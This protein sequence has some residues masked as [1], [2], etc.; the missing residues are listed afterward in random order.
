MTSVIQEPRKIYKKIPGPRGL[1]LLGVAPE[2]RK[3]SLGLS[4]K[5]IND[6]GPLVN[7]P[8][9]GMQATLTADPDL[10]RIALLET[11]RSFSK[12]PINDRLVAVIGNGLP[13]SSG[14]FWKQQRRL[15]NPAFT[16][17]NINGFSDVLTHE[18]ETMLRDWE[19]R[20][21]NNYLR[22]D[23]VT[24]MTGLTL[25]LILNFLFSVGIGDKAHRIAE[26]FHVL[27]VYGMKRFWSPLPLPISWPTPAN[28]QY[29]KAR[30][31]LD[32]I[33][34][35]IINERRS[36]DSTPKHDLLSLLLNSIDKD[37]GKGMSDEQL[38]DELM[39]LFFAGHDTTAHA[40]SFTFHLLGKNPDKL[41]KTRE[42]L[43]SVLG[44]RNPTPEDLPRLTYLRQ[45]F[46]E[47]LRVYPP[48]WMINRCPLE[49]F[50]YRDHLIPANSVI[51]LS[52][53]ALHRNPRLWERPDEFEPE[54]FSPER[55]LNRHKYAFIPFGAGSR[56]C[57]GQTL[58]ITESLTVLAITLQRFD[59]KAPEDFQLELMPLVT[60]NTRSGIPLDVSPL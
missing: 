60:L 40:L 46:D 11:E 50:E 52:I 35:D 58:A 31:E 44:G 38:R 45:V 37:T 2:F 42:E 30:A 29:R 54:R 57:I 20:L 47:A 4:M 23:I 32:S 39:S 48:A 12:A 6:Y 9:P 7:I 26:C 22:L 51:F 17:A 43:Q 28:L 34:F 15:A 25:R 53:F 5:L 10:V 24:Q 19:F 49:D 36:R 56:F 41:Q 3:D 14:D 27:S 8:M 18:T 16:K 1:P 21:K 13:F 59:F 55:S 33:I